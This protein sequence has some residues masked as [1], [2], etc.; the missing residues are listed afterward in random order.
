MRA[1]IR[2]AQ[3]PVLGVRLHQ[4]GDEAAPSRLVRGADP[5][6]DIAVK[7][8]V[9]Q[10]RVTPARIALELPGAAEDWSSSIWAAL[11]D[12]GKPAGDLVGHFV[13]CQTI[14]R[15]CRAFHGETVAVI[16]VI[17]P[18]A[19]IIRKFAGAQIGPRQFELPPNIPE[20]D[21]AGQ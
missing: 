18:S 19:S 6:S 15:P 11:E 12:R 10:Q 2:G 7:I 1:V 14:A 5:G 21:S 16:L 9:E 20:P 8:F 3:R 17:A 4:H 13:Q